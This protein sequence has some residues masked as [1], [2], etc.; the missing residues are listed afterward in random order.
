M[1]GLKPQT[2]MNGVFGRAFLRFA[3]PPP[4]YC[5]S[6]GGPAFPQ[7]GLNKQQQPKQNRLRPTDRRRFPY[8]NRALAAALGLHQSAIME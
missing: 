3:T 8:S 2:A 5:P 7:N 6:L 4:P 1:V